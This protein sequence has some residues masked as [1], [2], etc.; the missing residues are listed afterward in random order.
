M[1]GRENLK[2]PLI[3]S[4]PVVNGGHDAEPKL[5]VAAARLNR[6]RQARAEALYLVFTLGHGIRWRAPSVIPFTGFEEYNPFVSEL[7]RVGNHKVNR[8]EIAV[9]FPTQAVVKKPSVADAPI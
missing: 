1:I 2:R 3:V 4:S 6:L 9:G 5:A 7:H 8:T